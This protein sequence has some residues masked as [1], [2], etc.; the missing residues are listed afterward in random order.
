MRSAATIGACVRVAAEMPGNQ[1][2]SPPSSDD[3]GED[4]P[5]R[6]D[7]DDGS[8]GAIVWPGGEAIGAWALTPPASPPGPPQVPRRYPTLR[9]SPTFD[10][11]RRWPPPP[12]DAGVSGPAEA[13][14]NPWLVVLA[15]GLATIVFVLVVIGLKVAAGNDPIEPRLRESRATSTEEQ[16]ARDEIAKRCRY[17][18][19]VALTLLFY[20]AVQ[21]PSISDHWTFSV[22]TANGYSHNASVFKRTNGA[23]YIVGCHD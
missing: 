1:P 18:S 12:A 8:G 9:P 20:E 23:G 11:W 22:A 13:Q 7:G 17:P 5:A 15:V 3:H 14:G 2:P 4:P 19:P 6:P 16:G 21:D 10:A